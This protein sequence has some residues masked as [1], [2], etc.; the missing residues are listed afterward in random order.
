MERLNLDSTLLK[1][2]K[3]ALEISVDTLMP[4]VL[5]ENKEAEIT[6][7]ISLDHSTQH[8]FDNGRVT[9][10]WL[11]PEISFKLTEKLKENKNTREGML[12]QDYEIALGTDNKSYIKKVN[13]Q[14][15]LL[16]LEEG[17]DE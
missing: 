2:V 13:E 4:S 15:S 16:E 11:E 14:M 3:E 12:G 9:K 5:K 6:L 7:K 10:E 1:P 17:Q 8:E